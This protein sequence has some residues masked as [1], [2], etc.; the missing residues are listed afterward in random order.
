MVRWTAA[1]RR[2][3][4]WPASPARP[5]PAIPAASGSFSSA[6]SIALRTWLATK[7]FGQ[8]IDRLDQ[9]Q[10]GEPRLVDDAVGMHHLQHAVVERG[11]AGDV[12]ALA[13]RQELFEV[14]RRA[15]K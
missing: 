7:P 1:H 5:R 13:D 9:R 3:A 4:E 2:T 6:P 8:R 14:V 12:A 15:L 10:R 11:G